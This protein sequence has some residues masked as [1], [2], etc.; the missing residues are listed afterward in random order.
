[1]GVARST[2]KLGQNVHKG[3]TYLAILLFTVKNI[4]AYKQSKLW[5]YAKT[6]II[7]KQNHKALYQKD[8]LQNQHLHHNLQ[9]QRAHFQKDF[10]F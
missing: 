6:M 7:K 10:N 5:H 8:L 4:P 3:K 2:K 9:K 1:M